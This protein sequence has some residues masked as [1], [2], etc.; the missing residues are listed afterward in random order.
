[1]SYY[2]SASYSNYPYIRR[3]GIYGGIAD[4]GV[5]DK[6]RE[7]Y[8]Y[9][10]DKLITLIRQRDAVIR[11]L[12]ER[13]E[14]M[15]NAEE[16]LRVENTKLRALV[17]RYQSEL[18]TADRLVTYLADLVEKSGSLGLDWDK[19][20]EDGERSMRNRKDVPDWVVDE[21][22]RRTQRRRA[23]GTRELSAEFNPEYR[24]LPREVISDRNRQ[25]TLPSWALD[26]K[27]EKLQTAVDPDSNEKTYLVPKWLAGSLLCNT[28]PN[29]KHQLF[30]PYFELHESL[31]KE[32]KSRNRRKTWN[33][34]VYDNYDNEDG[35]KKD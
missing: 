17:P 14:A 33:R 6:E 7:L 10:N 35:Y 11:D 16:H 20:E 5:V 25:W 4:Y 19:M 23:D 18:A 8:R 29:D 3:T 12:N 9:D 1:M 34:D 2:R 32:L 26:Q 28:Q 30:D 15:A 24:L 22:I 13:L 21:L 31:I 27:I